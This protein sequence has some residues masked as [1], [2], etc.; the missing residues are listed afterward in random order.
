MSGQ[1]QVSDREYYRLAKCNNCKS[2][3]VL[4]YFKE[5]EGV[6]ECTY[7]GHKSPIRIST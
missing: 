1:K 3:S 2:K 6:K 7:C 5:K 4:H